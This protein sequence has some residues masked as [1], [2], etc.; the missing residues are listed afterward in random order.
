MP[1]T[2]SYLIIKIPRYSV[3]EVL[4]ERLKNGIIGEYIYQLYRFLENTITDYC[5]L[6][7]MKFYLNRLFQL[8]KKVPFLIGN[9]I[10]MPLTIGSH[11]NFANSI[12]N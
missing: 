7:K 1:L 5:N 3:S 12:F 4:A 2:G 6:L 8:P 10:K 11:V 9:V